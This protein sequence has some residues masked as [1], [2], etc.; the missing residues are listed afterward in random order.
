MAGLKKELDEVKAHFLRNYDISEDSFDRTNHLKTF[1]RLK[2]KSLV[3]LLL[4][5]MD[6]L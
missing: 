5:R 3:K 1:V 6:P 4:K 2:R